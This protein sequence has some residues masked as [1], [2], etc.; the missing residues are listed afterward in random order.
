M[1]C[2]L[3]PSEKSDNNW[4]SPQYFHYALWDLDMQVQGLSKSNLTST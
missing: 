1:A 3:A 2:L 4:T